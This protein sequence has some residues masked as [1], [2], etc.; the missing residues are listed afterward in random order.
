MEPYHAVCDWRTNL[1][2]LLGRTFISNPK[3]GTVQRV[4]YGLNLNK[5]IAREQRRPVQMPLWPI[6]K[7]LNC[8]SQPTHFE[9]PEGRLSR[10]SKGVAEI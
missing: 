2:L 5:S 10:L 6:Y 7:L 1:E 4:R 3:L 9:F 8:F